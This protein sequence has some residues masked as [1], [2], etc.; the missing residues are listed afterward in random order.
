MWIS[1]GS[2]IFYVLQFNSDYYKMR[3]KFIKS[4]F[5][6]LILFAA[7]L[8]HNKTAA[9][10]LESLTFYSSY[11]TAITSQLFGGSDKMA[12]YRAEGYGGGAEFSFLVYDKFYLNLNGGYTH[13]TINQDSALVQWHWLFWDRRYRSRVQADLASDSTLAA[14]ITP[15]QSMAVI[16]LMLTL[17]YKFQPTENLFITPYAGGGILFYTRSLFINEYWQKYF[18]QVD[19]TFGYSFRNF[20]NDKK[21]NPVAINGGVDITY[22]LSDIFRIQTKFNYLHVIKTEG[23]MGYDDFPYHSAL[24]F[25]LGIT[26]M[27]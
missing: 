15:V 27:Y 17:N 9:Q 1:D 4:Q 7:L 21:G 14:T 23:S 2:E 8:L 25:N 6:F 3:S 12:V 20:A 13:Y 5:I 24:N 10:N 16:P 22:K 18:G 19:Y 11:S 26:F